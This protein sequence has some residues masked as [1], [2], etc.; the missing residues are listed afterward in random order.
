MS[1]TFDG[2]NVESITYG[3]AE[4]NEIVY[5][6]VTVWSKRAPSAVGICLVNTG[7]GTGDWAWVNEDGT[8]VAYDNSPE[9]SQGTAVGLAQISIGGSNG[10]WHTIN[11]SGERL[12]VD[13]PVM[14]T[15]TP[16][17]IIMTGSTNTAA[18]TRLTEE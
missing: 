4:V 3:G 9:V 12:G 8:Q 13:N 16:V 1:L 11:E 10:E 2:T 17:G 14:S 18:W 6:G 7:N 15:D 5:N